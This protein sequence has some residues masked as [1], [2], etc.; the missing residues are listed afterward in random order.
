MTTTL[1]VLGATGG[2]GAAIAHAAAARGD[3]RVRAVNRGGT[4][5]VPGADVV[6]ADLETRAGA[7]AALGGIAATATDD[8]VVVLAAQPP[9]HDWGNGRFQRLLDSVL[10]AA[11]AL[12][13]K[14]VFVDNLY[15]FDGTAGPI[16]ETSPPA[17]NR[18]GVLREAIAQRALA[19]HDRGE[20]R[21]TIGCFSDY[22]GPGEGSDS[23]LSITMLDPALAGRRMRALYDLDVPHTFAYL[24]DM[25]QLFLT[26]ALDER[27]DGRRWVLPHG[28][29]RT[30]REVQTLVAEA[31]GVTPRHGVLG[32]AA[33]W[34]GGRFDKDVREVVAIRSQWQHPWEVDGGRF[35]A[36]FGSHPTTPLAEA[37]AT[38]VA[39]ARAATHAEEPGAVP[40]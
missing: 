20:L 3:L 31:V 15:A 38:T 13:A 28:P 9:Y 39:A 35:T 22:F 12:D 17:T 18:K 8:H 29:A 21:V 37:I 19:A 11:A 5:V 25:A 4:A 27:A 34:L 30:Q 14:L 2:I 32:A 6:A 23:T 16:T 7:T 26:L 1:T 10:G 24:P 40:A 36:V 33:M